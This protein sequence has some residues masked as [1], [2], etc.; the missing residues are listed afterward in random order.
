[1]RALEPARLWERTPAGSESARFDDR[2]PRTASTGT[3]RGGLSS[4]ARSDTM[5]SRISPARARGAGSRG[6]PS[7]ALSTDTDGGFELSS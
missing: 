7:E 5:A 6:S 4:P 2:I 1:M 3:D